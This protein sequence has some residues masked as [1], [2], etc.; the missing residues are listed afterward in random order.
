MYYFMGRKTC[1]R[2]TAYKQ[3]LNFKNAVPIVIDGRVEDIPHLYYFFLQ[4]IKK[5]YLF[6]GSTSQTGP[7]FILFFDIPNFP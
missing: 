1:P 5:N 3:A 2:M 4:I 7:A 6:Q